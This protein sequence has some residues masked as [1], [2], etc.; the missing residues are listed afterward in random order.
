V[1]LRFA[2]VAGAVFATTAVWGQRGATS[3]MEFNNFSVTGK[4]FSATATSHLVHTLEDGTHIDQTSTTVMYRDADGRTRNEAD[5]RIKIMDPVGHDEIGLD[6][7]THRATQIEMEGGV[8]EP[9]QGELEAS[10][11]AI[12][13]GVSHE[14]MGE[15]QTNKREESGG[16]VEDLGIKDHQRRPGSR[17]QDHSDYS[18]RVHRE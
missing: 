8:H 17:R 10:P 4:P 11:A 14:S 12:R 5:G 13:K 7:K 1:R 3:W 2:I 6:P 9:R 15:P 18:R 16:S